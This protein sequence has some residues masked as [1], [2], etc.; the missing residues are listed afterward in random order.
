MPVM[1]LQ[2]GNVRQM[3][4]PTIL[5]PTDERKEAINWIDEGLAG[6]PVPGFGVGTG[7]GNEGWLLPDPQLRDGNDLEPYRP[8][9]VAVAHLLER[10]AQFPIAGEK[11]QPEGR[12]GTFPEE[13]V[14]PSS[15]QKW[16]RDHQIV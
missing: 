12:S 11:T 15:P 9:Q 2:Q 3:D 4:E 14:R 6:L 16:N 13:H 7:M 5:I 1:V 10:P 8:L